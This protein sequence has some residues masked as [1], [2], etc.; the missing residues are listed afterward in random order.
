MLIAVTGATGF[1]GGKLVDSLLADGGTVRVLVRKENDAARFRE[2][3]T[4][5]VVS[6]MADI[7]GLREL[8]AGADLLYHLAAS[9]SYWSGDMKRQL[10]L[11]VGGTHLVMSAAHQAAVPRVLF[12]S[13]VAAIGVPTDRNPIDE[14]HP[15]NVPWCPYH[16]S[17]Y[18]S[19]LEAFGWVRKGIEVVAVN[20]SVVM[21]AGDMR[22]D[23][24]TM[25]AIF[26][27]ASGRQK[28]Y[29]TGGMNV[30]DVDDVVDGIRAAA[31]RGRS[32]QRYI[33]GG[34]NLTTYEV[35]ATM[36]GML[37]TPPPSIPMPSWLLTGIIAPVEL[38]SRLTHRA[39]MLTLAHARLS[40]A[41]NWFSHA[42]AARELGYSPKPWDET[43][44]VMAEDLRSK[45]TG[46][47]A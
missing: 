10:E 16:Y 1:I 6:D 12:V 47:A 2:L 22:Y 32:G 35:L 26:E 27:V 30:V 4:E 43:A 13:S 7:A 40:G 24:G 37:D 44:E 9:R 38:L 31:E 42:K 46:V 36:A 15:F 17:K 11:N 45:T 29:P 14:T 23:Q 28:V 39:P 34:S 20:P 18:L 5:V 3:G 8:C 33:L 25:R 19:E 41:Y 21:G